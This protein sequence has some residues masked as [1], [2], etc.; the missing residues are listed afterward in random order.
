M[1]KGLATKDFFKKYIDVCCERMA[2]SSVELD[3]V[4]IIHLKN[5]IH[6]SYLTIITKDYGVIDVGVSLM[7]T[8]IDTMYKYCYDFLID[9]IIIHPKFNLTNGAII[10]W[11][12]INDCP[13]FKIL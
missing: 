6:L 1:P 4:I 11:D 9:I 8:W 5:H 7:A 13:I 10:R 3:D 12:Y 2:Q